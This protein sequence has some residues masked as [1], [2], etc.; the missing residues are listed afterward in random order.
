M[1]EPLSPQRLAEAIGRAFA[2]PGHEADPCPA[3]RARIAAP[4][5]AG[6]DAAAL[7]R[8]VDFERRRCRP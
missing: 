8:E 1:R 2:L 6:G 4:S 5:L 7:A 3:N